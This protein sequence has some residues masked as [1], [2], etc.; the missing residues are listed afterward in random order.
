VTIFLVPHGPL[1]GSDL[2]PQ[3][4]DGAWAL[5]ESR[6]LPLDAVWLSAPEPA[7][8]TTTQ[9]LHDGEAGIVPALRAD[10]R[11]DELAATVAALRAEHPGDLVLVVP[12]DIER[13]R[14]LAVPDLIVVDALRS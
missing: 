13:W 11:A 14:A 4:Y 8:V 5:R 9:L 3:A 1:L 6:R 2:D 7:A 12:P 10:A